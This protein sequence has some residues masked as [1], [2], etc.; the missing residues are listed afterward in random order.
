MIP[1][2]EMTFV[3]ESFP[4]FLVLSLVQWPPHYVGRGDSREEDGFSEQHSFWL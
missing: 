3:W 1:A 2:S 4:D